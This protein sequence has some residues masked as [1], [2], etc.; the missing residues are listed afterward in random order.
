MSERFASPQ[1]RILRRAAVATRTGLSATS[2]WRLMQAGDFPKPV[3][4]G[5][6]A[7]GWIEAEVDAWIEARSRARDA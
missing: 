5:R 7:V 6:R 1:P 2:L 3:S 4:L